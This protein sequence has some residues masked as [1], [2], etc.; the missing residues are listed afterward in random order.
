M[1]DV[2]F[3]WIQQG[4]NSCRGTVFVCGFS[5]GTQNNWLIT[6]LINRTVDGARLQ[7]VNVQLEYEV[8]GC[9]ESL[10]CQRL[11]EVHKYETSSVDT[12]AARN[13]SNYELVT[14][15]APT[16]AS[17]QNRQNETITIE[18]DAETL[19]ASFY[20]AIRDVTSCI[21][22][23]RMLIFYTVCPSETSD[24]SI[25]TETIAPTD[26]TLLQ[27]STQ[28]VPNAGIRDSGGSSQSLSVCSQGGVW[29]T[30]P[31]NECTCN[32]G[33]LTVSQM[34]IGEYPYTCVVCTHEH[35]DMSLTWTVIFTHTHTHTNTQ[36][37]LCWGVFLIQF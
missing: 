1:N 13:T 30:L 14:S 11:F 8:L 33:F 2:T 24:L 9:E 17:G 28:C 3:Q 16:V 19:P 20:L 36:R 35:M 26:S 34:C 21:L 4:A 23:S 10:Q 25:R 37:L 29:T 6:Q 22:I 7:Q 18:F 27:I 5:A 15:V 32:P 31:N 12:T